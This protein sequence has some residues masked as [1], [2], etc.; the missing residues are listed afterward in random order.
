MES[1]EEKK[2]SEWTPVQ[3]IIE[4]LEKLG[5]DHKEEGFNRDKAI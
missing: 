5:I 2:A 1:K 4:A 3:R